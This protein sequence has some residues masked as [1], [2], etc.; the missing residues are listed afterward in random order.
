VRLPVERIVR[1]L[2]ASYPVRLVVVDGAQEYCHV[3]PDPR[4]ECYDLYLAG[5]HKWLGAH[6]P[7]GLAFC[8]RRRSRGFIETVLAR[9]MACGILDDPLLHAASQLE[10]GRFDG[11]GETVNLA[12][13]FSCHGA[14]ADAAD[15]DRTARSRNLE[16]V[17]H[18]VAGTGWRA[19]LPGPTFRSGILLLQ[20]ERALVRRADPAA[21]RAA[22]QDHGAALTAYPGGV[23]RLSMPDACWREQELG[24]LR[25]A[26]Q[27]TA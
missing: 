6:Q 5:A 17:T 22:F 14:A 18:L 7:L 13:L 12:P 10:D 4:V 9:L 25:R 16:Q 23:V 8:G 20:A 21:L 3:W 11:V 1:T 2:E 19:V 27:C 15:G 26:L 24:A